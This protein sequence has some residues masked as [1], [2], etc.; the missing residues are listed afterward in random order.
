MRQWRR[1]DASGFEEPNEFF[2]NPSNSRGDSVQFIG[3]PAP[4]AQDNI[5]LLG[6]M[7]DT[8]RGVPFDPMAPV[9]VGNKISDLGHSLEFSHYR[10]DRGLV[11]FIWKC[12]GDGHFKPLDELA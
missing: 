2:H 9:S 5:T 4:F 3:S 7:A 1:R 12:G 11:F 8:D 10:L 6:L